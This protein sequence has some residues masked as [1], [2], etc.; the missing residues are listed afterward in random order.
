[1]TPLS[2][3]Y[4]GIAALRN[5]V[6][7]RG[8]V[9]AK[10]LTAPVISI[11]NLSVG[12]SGKTPFVILLGELLSVHGFSVDV[13]SR[14]YGRKSSGVFQVDPQGS[15]ERF[16]DEPLLIARKLKRPVV[17]GEARYEAGRW[18]EAHLLESNG[19]RIHLLDDGFQ[20]R[21]L[22]RDFDIVLVTPEDIKDRL[23]PS[24]RLREP[25]AALRRADATVLAEGA[26]QEAL[27]VQTKHI[28]R[29][30]RRL[31]V[32]AINGPVIAFAGV[33]RPRRFFEELRRAGI[34]IEHEI[35]FRD[36]YRYQ[37]SDIRNLLRLRERKSGSAMM[38][39]EKDAVNLG[40]HLNALNPMV[41]PMK[42]ELNFPE[43]VVDTLLNTLNERCGCRA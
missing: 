9:K 31:D 32:P 13:L 4:G 1:M 19:R 42:M 26:A 10:R 6:Y 40:P 24:G 33:A 38:T 27:P 41:V 35:V 20:H 5:S 36:H 34:M 37:A 25:L 16:G 30:L 12:G 39:T 22:F 3:L 11:G 21:Q 23:V 14:G 18:A 43:K 7:D 29:V 15:A 8:I 17:V 2:A 28:W